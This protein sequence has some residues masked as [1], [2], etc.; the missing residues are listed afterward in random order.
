MFFKTLYLSLQHLLRGIVLSSRIHPTAVD[1]Y[2]NPD[3]RRNGVTKPLVRAAFYHEEGYGYRMYLSPLDIAGTEI[4]ETPEWIA[5]DM[6]EEFMGMEIDLATGNT[7]GEN[8]DISIELHAGLLRDEYYDI[9]KSP[10]PGT[11]KVSRG[12]GNYFE[13]ELTDFELADGT[14]LSCRAARIIETE[15]DQYYD[16]SL[17]GIADFS[18]D[19]TTFTSTYFYLEYYGVEFGPDYYNTDIYIWVESDNG[20]Q[21]YQFYFEANNTTPYLTSGKYSLL[22]G[23]Y[24]DKTFTES[25]H[26]LQIIYDENGNR[27]ETSNYFTAGSFD[28]EISDYYCKLTLNGDLSVDNPDITIPAATFTFD[29][30]K[31]HAR[32]AVSRSPQAGHGFPRNPAA[33]KDVL[34]PF[35][36]AAR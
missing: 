4:Y 35:G 22:S 36:N 2:L 21:A 17:A 31:Y 19:G 24:A 28:L 18:Y 23:S 9:P 7:K 1:P 26:F 5:I 27:S 20:D 16:L 34:K 33:G 14:R 6:P 3:S 13:V 15:Y 11:V 30:T 10:R 29:Y 25:S 8:V 12:E 32:S